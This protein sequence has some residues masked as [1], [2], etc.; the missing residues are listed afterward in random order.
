[1]AGRPCVP[2][3]DYTYE[4]QPGFGM[5]RH[6][7]TTADPGFQESDFL[8]KRFMA[9]VILVT[10]VEQMAN[11]MYRSM[12]NIEDIVGQ[13]NSSSPQI[14]IDGLQAMRQFSNPGVPEHFSGAFEG[15]HH[16]KHFL[17]LR[18]VI[19][20]SLQRNHRP[21]EAID[22]L[23]GLQNKQVPMV[24][25]V[26]VSFLLFAGTHRPVPPADVRKLGAFRAVFKEPLKH[27]LLTLNGI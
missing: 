16:T 8:H 21:L 7:S 13:G 6:A 15:V 18:Q 24:F 25:N 14:I 9:V 23:N 3:R 10:A 17:Q 26:H 20:P 11:V 22:Q 27:L 19:G 2:A 5:G 12:G 4:I 1:M